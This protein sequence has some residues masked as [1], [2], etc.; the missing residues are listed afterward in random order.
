MWKLTLG[1]ASYFRAEVS[2]LDEYASICL[3]DKKISGTKKISTHSSSFKKKVM[4]LESFNTG[5]KSN[6]S[7]VF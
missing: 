1:Y 5:N 2:H 7:S 3:D 4:K 6:F